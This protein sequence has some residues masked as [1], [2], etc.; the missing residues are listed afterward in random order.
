[1]KTSSFSFSTQ[2]EHLTKKF[3][4]SF[5]HEL[6]LTAFCSSAPSNPFLTEQLKSPNTPPPESRC[7]VVRTALNAPG[8]RPGFRRQEEAFGQRGHRGGQG[9][10][11]SWGS[12]NGGSPI[13][14]GRFLETE[15][16]WNSQHIS[17]SLSLFNPYAIPDYLCCLIILVSTSTQ[18]DSI[19]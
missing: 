7:I 19:I 2:E 17:T 11:N 13:P 6:K 12:Q 4:F 18:L 1:M 8:P 10:M 5:C 3:N 14:E 9:S 16:T 15:Q